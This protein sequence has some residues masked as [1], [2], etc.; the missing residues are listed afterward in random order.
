MSRKTRFYSRLN[1]LKHKPL[2]SRSLSTGAT[3]VFL[4]FPYDSASL[5]APIRLSSNSRIFLLR[6]ANTTRTRLRHLHRVICIESHLPIRLN[7]FLANP[8]IRLHKNSSPLVRDIIPRGM[9][10]IVYQPFIVELLS[11]VSRYILDSFY[12]SKLKRNARRYENCAPLSRNPSRLAMR[13]SRKGFVSGTPTGDAFSRR[14][15]RRIFSRKLPS[16]RYYS[17][18][19]RESLETKII[20]SLK[21]QKF[22]YVSYP[23]SLH[24]FFFFHSTAI[25]ASTR[26]PFFFRPARFIVTL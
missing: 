18:H 7:L 10:P 4:L 3:T 15:E 19:G 13:S 22:P 17:R 9:R 20:S 5:Y 25:H 14:S 8:A 11:M 2:V 12:R 26:C 21:D 24:R 1:K 16:S 23:F 6:A